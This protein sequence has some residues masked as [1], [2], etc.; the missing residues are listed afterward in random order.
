[1]PVPRVPVL[2]APLRAGVVALALPQP[3]APQL[4]FDLAVALLPQPE[5]LRST[6]GG[7]DAPWAFARVALRLG[8]PVT[9]PVYR[10][11]PHLLLRPVTAMAWAC[12][13]LLFPCSAPS[14]AGGGVSENV[15]KMPGRG[16]LGYLV[17]PCT[18]S[19]IQGSD[20][21]G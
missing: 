11:G 15:K 10:V 2:Q 5:R 12:S 21:L 14:A 7:L 18:T 17:K 8:L 13:A 19:T 1:M 3:L 20:L 6:R 4:G 16:L 9:V